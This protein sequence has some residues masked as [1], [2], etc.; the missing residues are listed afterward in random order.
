MILL[1]YV[2]FSFNH[3]HLNHQIIKNLKW[4]K[5]WQNKKLMPIRLNVSKIFKKMSNYGVCV[6]KSY[7]HTLYNFTIKF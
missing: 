4:E 7:S 2:S 1:I 6:L 3:Y 5:S